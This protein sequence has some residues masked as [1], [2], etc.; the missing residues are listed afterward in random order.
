[1]LN[2]NCEVVLGIVPFLTRILDSFSGKHGKTSLSEKEE[3]RRYLSKFPCNNN[4]GSG[5]NLHLNLNFE[6][7]VWCK[8]DELLSQVI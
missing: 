1:M 5:S 2:T 7:L 3:S 4:N 8:D 6:R